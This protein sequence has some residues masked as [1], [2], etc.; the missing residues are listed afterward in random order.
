M[1]TPQQRS[2]ESTHRPAPT[3]T[4]PLGIALGHSLTKYYRDQFSPFSQSLLSRYPITL[5]VLTERAQVGT[6][7]LLCRDPHQLIIEGVRG[8]T[9]ISP[10]TPSLRR[11]RP[12]TD[13]TESPCWWVSLPMPVWRARG[14][15]ICSHKLTSQNCQTYALA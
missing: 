15:A 4:I 3:N 2:Y 13:A 6:Q 10:P 7:R 11:G 5:P 8:S 1:P 9:P 14:P 12:V